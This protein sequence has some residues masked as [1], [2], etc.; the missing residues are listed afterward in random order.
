MTD[1]QYYECRK[2]YARLLFTRHDESIRDIAL[3]VGTDEATVR[4]WI[5]EGAWQ[6]VRR[7]LLTSKAAQLDHLYNAVERLNTRLKSSDEPNVKE[8]DQILKYT[9]AI[10]NL[11]TDTSVTEIIEVSELFIRWLRRKDLALTKKLII[12]LDA[13]IKHIAT[14]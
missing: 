10:K 5:N 11:E 1:D 3:A 4:L 14:C 13:Y 2:E 7:T 12:Y 9:A 6:T 8:V